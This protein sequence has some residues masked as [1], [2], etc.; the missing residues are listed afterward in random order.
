MMNFQV[1]CS[2]AG[3]RLQSKWG[4]LAPLRLLVVGEQRESVMGE[5]VLSMI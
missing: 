4:R 5:R 3:N 2:K 1:R